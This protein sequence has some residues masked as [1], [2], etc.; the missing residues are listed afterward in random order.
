MFSYSTKVGYSKIDRNGQVP[1]YEIMNYLQDCTNFHSESL[2]C[3][4]EYMESRGRAWIIVAYKIKINQ[5]IKL[6]QDIIVGTSP[7]DFGSMF[8]TRQF[9]IK[10]TDGEFLV[11]ADTL[12]VIMDMDKRRPTRIT[13]ED[14]SFYET[15]QVFDDVK[16]SRKIKFLDQGT[17]QDEF[18]VKKTFIDNNGHMNN[19]DYL[20]VAEEYLPDDFCGSQVEIVYNKEAM[21]GQRVISYLHNE[22][23][24]IGMTFESQTGEILTKIKF[25]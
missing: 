7:T 18:V 15:E 9:F 2:G 10:N 8:A 14:A 16:A 13:E 24:G 1:F 12:W 22:E 5:P 20:R 21:E 3:G 25:K 19:A 4:L 11:Q 23:D 17:S 6:G